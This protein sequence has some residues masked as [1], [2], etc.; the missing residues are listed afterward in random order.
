MPAL[1]SG[2]EAGEDAQ[3]F[4]NPEDRKKALFSCSPSTV[5]K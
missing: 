3:I 4:K 5:V 1:Q 2:F